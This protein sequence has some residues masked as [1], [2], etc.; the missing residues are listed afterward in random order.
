MISINKIGANVKK[1]RKFH[2]LTQ[3]QLAELVDIS[4]V[5]MSHIETGSVTMSLELLLKICE[6]LDITPNHLLLDEKNIN[7][8]YHLLDEKI[9]SLTPDEREF[10]V[11]MIDL[12]SEAKLNR[13]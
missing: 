10:L 7:Q 2:R 11:N 8:D 1:Y 12:L 9:S 3:A 6:E 13:S 5:H 4:T